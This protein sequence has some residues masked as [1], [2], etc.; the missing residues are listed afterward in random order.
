MR[1]IIDCKNEREMAAVSD[2]FERL[3]LKVI[4]A[5]VNEKTF[6]FNDDEA[7]YLSF[8]PEGRTPKLNKAEIKALCEDRRN[9]M[10]IK[11]IADKYK[12]SV[13]YVKKALEVHGLTNKR[14]NK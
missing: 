4:S 2:T 12:V 7:L 3:N 14:L 8:N 13:P 5:S 11:D 9:G 6:V 1:F 10:K